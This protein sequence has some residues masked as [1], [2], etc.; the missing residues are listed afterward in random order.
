LPPGLISF[1]GR[2]PMITV[3]RTATAFPGMTGEAISWAKEPPSQRSAFLEA[4]AVELARLPPDGRGP[5]SLSRSARHPAPSSRMA[6]SR[7]VPGRAASTAARTHCED[8]A[9]A[10][11]A[12]V[13]RRQR[14]LDRAAS[15]DVVKPVR[16]ACVARMSEAISGSNRWFTPHVVPPMRDTWRRPFHCEE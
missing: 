12:G 1:R 9:R 10:A 13:V 3:I 16:E 2:L 15:R 11:R 4:I 6:R 5:G 8:E 14:R 7:A